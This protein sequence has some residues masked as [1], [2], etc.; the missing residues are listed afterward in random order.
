MFFY[1]HILD[2]HLVP[3][4]SASYSEEIGGERGL[5]A[6]QKT[7]VKKTALLSFPK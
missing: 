1:F 4:P 6:K 7:F 5:G 2:L 3:A